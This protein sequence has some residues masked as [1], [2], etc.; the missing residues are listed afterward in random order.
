MSNLTSRYYK[1]G[2]VLC[3]PQRSADDEQK[4]L[5]LRRRALARTVLAA[6]CSRQRGQPA[7][8]QPS[9][10]Q[11]L[12]AAAL[13]H[14]KRRHC[15][16]ATRGW[17]HVPP[18]KRLS[19]CPSQSADWGSRVHRDRYFRLLSP[20][21][22]LNSSWCAVAEMQREL[23]DFDPSVQKVLL[24]ILLWLSGYFP[25]LQVKSRCLS[26]FPGGAKGQLELFAP[27][28][29]ASVGITL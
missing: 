4:R 19:I 17:S 14:G 24:I 13:L 5:S 20:K 15:A 21:I 23:T 1:Q 25:Q 18:C 10:L 27:R 9:A 3:L 12:P 29:K 2:A 7:P 8:A 16:P 6:P 22:L 11:A 28:R 26:Y